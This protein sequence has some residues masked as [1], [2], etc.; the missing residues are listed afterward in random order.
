[1][2]LKLPS[3][4]DYYV[5]FN[6]VTS[7]TIDSMNKVIITRAGNNRG[8]GDIESNVIAKLGFGESFTIPNVCLWEL[9]EVTVNKIDLNVNPGYADVTAKLRCINDCATLA[10]AT[11]DTWTGID[12]WTTADLMSGSNSLTKTPDKSERLSNCHEPRSSL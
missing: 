6:R 7:G 3:S 4:I 5:L 8:G 1:M 9:L 2:I 11:L 10:G 12:R